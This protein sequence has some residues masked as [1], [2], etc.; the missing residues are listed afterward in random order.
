MYTPRI[1]T[2]DD[3]SHTIVFEEDTTISYHSVHGAITESKHVFIENGLNHVLQLD[4]INVLEIGLGTGLNCLLTLHKSLVEKLKI[5]YFAY[6]NYPLRAELYRR[7]NYSTFL[8]HSNIQD[9]FLQIHQ[10]SYNSPQAISSNFTLCK[11]Q[12]NVLEHSLNQKFH[13]VYFDAFS[14]AFQPEL[15]TQV[16]FQKIYNAMHNNAL[17]TTYCAKG[18]V[19]RTLKAIGFEVVNVAGPPFKREITL[20]FKR[21]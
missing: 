17:L 1:I 12:S 16:L 21:E 20:A 11:Y 4:N 14:P 19:K 5:N 9:Y 18:H 15:W 7:L 13:L 10:A 8:N 6:E 2:T 3:G